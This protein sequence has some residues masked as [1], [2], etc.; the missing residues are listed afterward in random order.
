MRLAPA[1]ASPAAIVVVRGLLPFLPAAVSLKIWLAPAGPRPLLRLWNTL[2][3]CCL[4]LGFHALLCWWTV[5]VAVL[6]VA[7]VGGDRFD[8]D[9]LFP[10]ALRAALILATIIALLDAVVVSVRL[11]QLRAL[12]LCGRGMDFCRPALVPDAGIQLKGSAELV[13]VGSDDE[14]EEED[15]EEEEEEEEEVEE[16][17]GEGVEQGYCEGVDTAVT[18]WRC[19]ACSATVRVRGACACGTGPPERTSGP[20]PVHPSALALNTPSFFDTLPLREF[21]PLEFETLWQRLPASGGFTCRVLQRCS[22]VSLETHLRR[23]GFVCVA[24][25]QSP[26]GAMNAYFAAWSASDSRPF[27]TFLCRF[28]FSTQASLDVVCKCDE[29]ALVP[30]FVK[31]FRLSLLLTPAAAGGGLAGCSFN[32]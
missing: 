11:L 10:A 2:R 1:G 5:A 14:E 7:S 16:E 24:S 32:V 8:A 3:L 6:A 27:A 4:L 19:H 29:A 22:L 18:P 31:R 21:S 25:G 30:A 9:E 15:A 28:L 20:P 12:G 13:G 26:E 23:Q 17:A